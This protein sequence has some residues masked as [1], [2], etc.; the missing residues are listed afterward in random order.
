MSRGGGAEEQ[1]GGRNAQT[2]P[3]IIGGQRRLLQSEITPGPSG[4]RREDLRYGVSRGRGRR[5]ERRGEE[6]VRE[7]EEGEEG[8][9]R[10]REEEKTGVWRV[11]GPS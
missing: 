3:S 2:N 5:G 4:Q 6:E 9:E 10:R 7:E 1:A 11:N 8:E